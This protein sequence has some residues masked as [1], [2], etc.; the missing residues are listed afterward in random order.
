M[1]AN[2]AGG[3]SM[4]WNKYSGRNIMAMWVADLDFPVAEPIHEA[5]ARRIKSGIY[6]YCV[7]TERLLETI[8]NY[9]LRKWNWT[10][11]PEW[12]VFSPGLGVA[13]HTVCRLP[14]LDGGGILTPCPIYT[15]FR[16]APGFAGKRRIDVPWRFQNGNMSLSAQDFAAADDGRGKVMMLCN[17][18]NPNGHV[19]SRAELANLAEIAIEKDWI[20]CTDDVHADLVLDTDR[21]YVPIATLGPEVAARTIHL[22][23]PGKAFNI[24]GLQFAVV[25]IPDKVLRGRYA[26]AKRGQVSN[27]LNPIGMAAGE[28]AW[29]GDCDGWLAGL[30]SCLRANRDMLAEGIAQ[31]DGLSMTHLASTFLA[32]LDISAL[33]LADPQEHFSRHG[34]GMS[35]GAEFG[36]ANHMRLNFG[37]DRATVSEALARLQAAAASA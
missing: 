10:I 17:P 4:R 12:I 35:A 20:I 36:D 8:C 33:R 34:L 16:T 32:W 9:F 6:G 26:T 31:T 14:G 3:D 13:I 22:Q 1:R 11:S 37:T 24:A 7:P 27:Q 5:I 21:N 18:H 30:I 15:Q 19:F 29:S 28:A 25:V 23:G 2:L